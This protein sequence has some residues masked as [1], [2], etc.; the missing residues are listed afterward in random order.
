MVNVT[1]L[2]TGGAFSAGD[3]S[4]LALLIE[5]SD[6]HMLIESGPVIMQQLAR[7]SLRASD[8]EQVFVSHA[9]GDH[10]LGFP[11]LAL[12]RM[13]AETPLQIYAGATTIAS[14]RIL[15]AVSF[16][17]LSPDG[18]DLRWHEL[19][20][21]G[22]DG[23]SWPSDVQ[24]RTAVVDHPPGLPTLSARWEFHGGPSITFVT[25]TRP[26]EASVELAWESDLL[27][28]EASFSAVLEP[29]A[30]PA[31]HYHSTAAQAG[32]TAR[33]AACKRLALVHLGPQIGRHPDILTREARNGSDLDVIIPD[34]GQVL[35][36]A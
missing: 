2:G 3:R 26:G 34:D 15:S 36:V 29:D 13:D 35:T 11:I 18:I 25:D 30:E 14:L 33:K 19:S 20:E 10:V 8:I 31:K 1:F 27:I 28:H 5:S 24:L 22:P 23:A 17:S 4:P 9:H 21:E 12:N 7:A 32:E 16:S 6:F